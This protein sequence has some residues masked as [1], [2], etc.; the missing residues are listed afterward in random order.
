[1][2]IKSFLN[3]A[4]HGK[5]IFELIRFIF[6]GG[7]AT[8]TDLVVT[9]CLFFMFPSLHENIVTTIAFLIAFFVSYFGHSKVTFQKEGSIVKFFALSF[10]MLLLRN[11]ILFLLVTFVM[12]GLIPIIISMILVTAI[13]FV[14]SKFFVFKDP[15][16][17]N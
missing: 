16:N 2:S 14:V 13:T 1:M 4:Y 17:N 9:I 11:V 10:S 15:Q 12:R 6:I 3:Q 5:G 8:I 7:L